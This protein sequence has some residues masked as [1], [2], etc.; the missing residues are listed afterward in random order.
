MEYV[1]Q[2]TVNILER[3]LG[4]MHL[5]FLTIIAGYM[6]GV[7]LIVER[8][9]TAVEISHG[10]VSARL[11]GKTYSMGGGQAYAVDVPELIASQLESDAM[12]V[13]TTITTTR[14]Q[15][16]DNCTDPQ[17]PCNSDAD[18]MRQ[19]PVAYGL[20]EDGQCMQLGWCPRESPEVSQTTELQVARPL[21]PTLASRSPPC[22]PPAPRPRVAE[23][24]RPAGRAARGHR[25]PA[26][27]R[28]HLLHGGRPQGA[29]ALDAL[30][31]RAQVRRAVCDRG[32]LTRPAGA[33]SL[34]PRLRRRLHTRPDAAA[35]GPPP[36]H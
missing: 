27:R 3:R 9:Y 31:H 15:K 1:S 35:P 32:A 30:G 17:Q 18:C 13:P 28:P 19:P 2:K 11:E 14:S 25:V 21:R 10:F 20:C 33:A 26:P 4:L 6:L 8:G 12:F 23:P 22:P 29:H 5:F 36:K 16:Q 34:A 24:E 7:R